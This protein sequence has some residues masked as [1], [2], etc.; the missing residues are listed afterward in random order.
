[1]L[2]LY[3]ESSANVDIAAARERG[4][5]V[6]GIRDYGDEG[7]VEYVISELVRLLHGFGGKQW[8]HKAYELGG[9]KVGIVGLGRT[10]RMIADALRFLGAEV[11]YFSRTRKPM[12]R[13][14]V[15][16]TCLCGS[17]CRKWIFY[18]LACLV[19]RFFWGRVSFVCSVI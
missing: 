5:T 1:M 4:I 7:V 13:P 19:I 15:S 8:K 18:V 17:C 10:G 9:Q 6:L 3:S 11:Y 2:Y 16:L 12:P 14:P